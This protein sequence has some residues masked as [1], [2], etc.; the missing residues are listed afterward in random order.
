MDGK[1]YKIKAVPDDPSYIDAFSPRFDGRNVFWFDDS[2]R[3]RAAKAENLRVERDG[4]WNFWNPKQSESIT[5]MPV[6]YPILPPFWE[7]TAALKQVCVSPIDDGRAYFRPFLCRGN[8][9]NA[10]T[11]LVG[12]NPATPIYPHDISL[13][14]YAKLLGNYELFLAY[15][16][17]RRGRQGKT[18]I[19]PTRRGI[20]SLGK[21]LEN[22]T[23]APV[24]ETNIIAYPTR[25]A[26]DLKRE[27]DYILQ[28]GSQIFKSLL[29]GIRPALI[30][31]HGAE[32]IEGFIQVLAETGLAK[33]ALS[34][35]EKK[36]EFAKK[37]PLISFC[38]EDG[39][40]A[41]V[42]A[43]RHLRFY[44]N[45]GNSYA[46]FRKLISDSMRG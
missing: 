30:V 29:L 4:S 16:R 46:E 33:D 18:G 26:S 25:K 28:K 3:E 31:L 40:L 24:L 45:E 19:S 23:S 27:P 35:N 43:C 34:V 20:D 42:F 21:W 41:K 10:R 7:S 8:P 6:E 37:A 44:G 32:T 17:D 11:F 22:L 36:E 13:D 5:F 12:I 2:G 39:S 15:Y 9:D 38:Y 1:H 14:D